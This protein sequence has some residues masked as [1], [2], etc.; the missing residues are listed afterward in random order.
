MGNKLVLTGNY[1]AAE[2]AALCRPDLIAAYPITPQ[3]A[4]HKAHRQQP[5]AHARGQQAKQGR[6]AHVAYIG[7]GHLQADNAL[8][9]RRAE[10]VRRLV[11]HAG[12]SGRKAQ[13]HHTKRRRAK[14]RGK[15][16]HARS[17]QGRKGTAAQDERRR[18]QPGRGKPA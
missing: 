12:V 14:R 9:S 18:R 7:R 6:H 1:A 4:A 3:T 8:R 2:A 17:P 16:A 15:K 11:H 13:A 5:Y 10:A